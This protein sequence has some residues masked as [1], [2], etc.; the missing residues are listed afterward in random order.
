MSPDKNA[1]Q[2][3]TLQQSFEAFLQPFAN[4]PR[5]WLA[6]SG[7]LDST[8][9]L[10]LVSQL[11]GRAKIPPL[12]VLHINHQL[13]TAAD[14]WQSRCSE[15]CD[16]LDLEFTG[17]LVEVNETG[18]GLEAAA[19]A[20]RYQVFEE[21]VGESECLLLAHH[22]DDQAETFL[23]RLLRGAGVDGLAGMPPQRALGRG[24][25]LRPLLSCGRADLEAY[26]EVHQLNWIEDS[27]NEDQSLDRNYLRRS[28]MPL[29]E[30]RW[31]AYR[32]RIEAASHNLQEFSQQSQAEAAP[33]ITT[34]MGEA[35]GEKTLSLE[36]WAELEET[37]QRR[38]IRY[39]LQSL[40]VPMPDRNSLREFVR[41][42]AEADPGAQP[43]LRTSS[44]HLRCYGKHLY[45]DAVPPDQVLTPV[46]VPCS[47]AGIR[48]EFADDL[49]ICPRKGGERCRPS[50]RAHS[51]TLK[52]LL[53]EHG[54]PPWQREDLPLVLN[55]VGEVVA[56]ADLW[57]CAGFE[58][59]PEEEG[60]ELVWR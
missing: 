30:Q 20:A 52:K 47:G 4:R 16:E 40:E 31:P 57:V 15:L 51:Q 48:A 45:L 29:L 55:G 34:R 39:W 54:V 22:L 13:H 12:Q 58:A 53:Q 60:L 2:S 26:A 24:E 46:L 7:G 19:R 27:S 59:K 5:W 42:L 33:W 43:Q 17:V 28:V 37:D 6:Y 49:T 44:Y 56:V 21:Y 14:Q 50:G 3:N 25:L 36:D 35:F 41:Q 8:V 10:H 32:Q 11:K 38:M 23:L 1:S 18:S 9:L